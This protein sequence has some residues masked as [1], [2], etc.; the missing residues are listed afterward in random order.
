MEMRLISP[1]HFEHYCGAKKKKKNPLQYSGYSVLNLGLYVVN[2]FLQESELAAI[3][4][5]K[6]SEVSSPETLSGR[7][8]IECVPRS[9]EFAWDS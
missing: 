9:L 3:R 4:N 7:M 1:F 2:F 5:L 8:P 6:L